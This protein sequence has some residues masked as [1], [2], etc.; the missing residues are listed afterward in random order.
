MKCVCRANCSVAARVMMAPAAMAACIVALLLATCVCMAGLVSLLLASGLLSLLLASGLLLVWRFILPDSVAF[1]TST[2]P[3]AARYAGLPPPPHS[4]HPRTP[5]PPHPP[6]K[7]PSHLEVQGALTAATTF[8]CR[9]EALTA[10]LHQC[11]QGQG[12]GWRV[13]GAVFTKFPFTPT[14]PTPNHAPAPDDSPAPPPP[15][16]NPLNPLPACTTPP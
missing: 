16:L 12:Q 8:R 2:V 7:H 5:H 3:E 14:L 15:P 11:T 13:A 4:H 10:V 9:Q 1:Y 6:A